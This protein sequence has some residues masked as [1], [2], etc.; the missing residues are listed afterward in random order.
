MSDVATR[1]SG[2]WYNQL[3]SRL[4]LEADGD[5][6]L[7]GTLSSGVGGATGSHTVTGRYDPVPEDDGSALGFVVSWPEAHSVTVWSGHYHVAD[8]AIDATWLLAGEAPTEGEWHT[9]H[10]GHDIF[11]RGPVTGA[12]HAVG[13]R[14][15]S[16]PG[17]AL[18]PRS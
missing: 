16:A 17:R 5:G 2:V 13:A 15:A 6:T 9:T 1:I 18:E 4:E 12:R 7:A 3:G 8:D 14:R 10:I 11:S